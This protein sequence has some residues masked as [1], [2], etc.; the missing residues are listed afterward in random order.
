M[1]K[2]IC[3]LSAFSWF[4]C[5]EKMVAITVQVVSCVVVAFVVF[6]ALFM[7]NKLIFLN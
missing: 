4:Y 5:K 7:Q 1:T 2:L 6:Y 3:E